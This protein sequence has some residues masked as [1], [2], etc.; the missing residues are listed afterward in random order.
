MINYPH[1]IAAF[2][3]SNEIN[4]NFAGEI[5]SKLKIYHLADETC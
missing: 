4:A 1:Q 5:L 3:L 2:K